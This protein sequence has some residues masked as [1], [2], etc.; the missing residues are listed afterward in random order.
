[1]VKIII[2]ILIRRIL[3]FLWPQFPSLNRE[4]ISP[5]GMPAAAKP[6]LIFTYG[7]L[8]RG[9]SNHRLLQDMMATGDATFLGRCRTVHR[10][11]LVC[12]P[13][14]VP[15][16]L[17]FAGRGHRVSGEIY[18]VSTAAL[19][20]MDELEG[21]SRGH[22]ERLPIEIELEE[23]GKVLEV[24]AYYGH[25]SYAEE[26]WRRSGE[27]G[28]NCYTDKVARGYVYRKDRPQDLTFL[29]QIRLF[30]SSDSQPTQ[31]EYLAQ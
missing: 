24:E 18:A 19:A 11:P 16:L 8:K 30:L 4:N 21:L 15:F 27:E 26:M 2:K 28:Y 17:N 25:R 13:Y 23:E 29:D 12:G 1:M 31:P 3:P 5:M 20:R 10:L 6:T 7:T 22:Y 9:F 14:R